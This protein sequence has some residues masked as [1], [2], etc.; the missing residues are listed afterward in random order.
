MESWQ[1]AV[2]TI[3]G[4]AFTLALLPT[5]FGQWKPDWK[6]AFLTATI[7]FSFAGTY[8][9]MELWFS[10]VSNA[11]LALAWSIV[12]FQSFTRQRSSD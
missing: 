1:D 5:I 6:T 7:T 9:V 11:I 2:F 10:A 3:G 4:I 8:I 12:F